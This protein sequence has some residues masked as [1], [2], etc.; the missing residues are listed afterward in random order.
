MLDSPL[1]SRLLGKKIGKWLVCAK[2]I[3]TQEDN[4]GFFSS[5]YEVEDETGKKA[6]LKAFNYHYA[7]KSGMSMDN[8]KWMS[9]NFT[10]ERD[11]L[12]Y[13]RDHRMK[14][15]VTAMDSGEYIERGELPV[16]YLVFELAEGNIKSFKNMNH[17]GIAWKLELFHGALVGLFQLHKA[18]IVHQDIKPSN[19]LIFGNNVSKISDLGTATR[20]DKPSNWDR[21]DLRYAPIELL[22]S[23]YSTNWDTRRY[24]A[25]L[26]MMGG[27]L[28]FLLVG[29]KFL[30]LILAKI[31]N[32]KIPFYG[33]GGTFEEVRPLLLEAYHDALRDL[34]CEIP[35]KICADLLEVLGELTHPIPEDRGNPKRLQRVHQQYSLQRY[36]SV[37]DRLAKEAKYFRL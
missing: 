10:Y 1:A 8:L 6:F 33:Y 23:Y 27:I 5:C 15:V 26:F 16:P 24:G 31:P 22:Y 7:F 17:P 12:E 28:C 20:L 9:E 30:Q 37:I 34:K 21:G 3:K 4:S 29:A 25:D 19:I 14:R 36:I 13:C 32:D 35:V 18:K 11:L 2:K